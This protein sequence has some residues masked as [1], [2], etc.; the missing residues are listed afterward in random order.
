MFGKLDAKV[1]LRIG[2]PLHC[3]HR[4]FEFTIANGT[5]ADCRDGPK[6]FQHP[7]STFFHVFDGA[8]AH[9]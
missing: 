8:A 2:N 3:S 9:L 7:K 4:N 1:F 6:P 5:C